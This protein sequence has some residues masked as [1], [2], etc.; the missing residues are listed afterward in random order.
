MNKGRYLVLTF[1]DF[2]ANDVIFLQQNVFTTIERHLVLVTLVV[3]P[4]E[5]SLP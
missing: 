2:I 5:A 4:V 1:G 3:E